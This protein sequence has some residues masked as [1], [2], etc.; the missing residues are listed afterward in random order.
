VDGEYEVRRCPFVETT[1]R[2][3]LETFQRNV[4]TKRLLGIFCAAMLCEGS[5]FPSRGLLWVG[6]ITL[7][8]AVEEEVTISI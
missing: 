8:T 7:V 2:V 5:A 6:V 4:S 3:V 1:R